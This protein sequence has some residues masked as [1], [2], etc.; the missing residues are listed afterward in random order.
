MDL[1]IANLCDEFLC[2]ECNT[3]EFMKKD[4]AAFHLIASVSA[5]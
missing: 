1:K 4:I 3:F 2:I 5:T